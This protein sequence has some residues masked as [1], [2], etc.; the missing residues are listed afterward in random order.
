MRL[1]FS[2]SVIISF[3]ALI[4][5]FHSLGE[6]HNARES[7]ILAAQVNKQAMATFNQLEPA[8]GGQ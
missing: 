2:L 5:A 4:S 7:L 1:L 8:A 6:F 3:L